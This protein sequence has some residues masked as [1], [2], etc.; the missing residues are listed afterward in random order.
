M[1]MDKF[2]NNKGGMMDWIAQS[3]WDKVNHNLSIMADIEANHI[4]AKRNI[5]KWSVSRLSWYIK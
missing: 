4:I 5:H 3:M 2:W 1:E